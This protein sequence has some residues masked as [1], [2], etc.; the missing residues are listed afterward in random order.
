M[1][2][3][4]SGTEEGRSVGASLET[5]QTVVYIEIVSVVNFPIRAGQS[6]TVAAQDVI[7]YVLIA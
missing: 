2:V 3:V 6:I 5:G 4:Y 1:E 7:V